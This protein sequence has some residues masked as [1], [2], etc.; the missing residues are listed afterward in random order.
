MTIEETGIIMDILTTAYPRFY[1]GPNAPDMMKT[2]TLWAEMFARDDVALVAAAVKALIESDSK[3]FPPHIGAVKEKLRLIS[4]GDEMTEAEA[5]GIVAKALRNSAYGSREEFDKFPPV[6]KRIVG[7]PSQ[8]R[9]WSMMDSET[10]HSV[11]ASNFQ[12]SYKAIAQREK[13]LAKLPPDVKA[14]VGK[15]ADAKKIEVLP[16][17]KPELPPEPEARAVPAP[18]AMLAAAISPRT[19]R[20]REEV[21]A[22]LRE[23]VRDG[24]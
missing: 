17:K 24:G 21:L 9:E 3:G 11:V 12:R 19:G 4:A 18:R 8:L 15:L 14:L 5:W 2:L 10:V 16:E 13:E 7:S 1:S 6:I 22:M 23:G 20:S